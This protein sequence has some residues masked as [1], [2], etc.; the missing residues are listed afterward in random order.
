MKLL[1]N[2]EVIPL[3]KHFIPYLVLNSKKFLF[4]QYP[5]IGTV[6]KI[7]HNF[8]YINHLNFSDLTLDTLLHVVKML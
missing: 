6:L 7:S 8:V 4:P 3:S 2:M 1:N 5:N